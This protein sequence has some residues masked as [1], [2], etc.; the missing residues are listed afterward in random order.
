TPYVT[1]V[2]AVQIDVSE[3]LGQALIPFAIVVVGLSLVLLTIVFRSILVQVKAAFGYL[4]SVLAA[5][6]VV[7]LV[8][9][10]G[11]GASLLGLDQTGPVI[12]FLPIILMGILFGLAMDYEVF[13]VSRIREEHVHG[14]SAREAIRTGFVA[15]SRVVLAAGLI[16][17]AVFAAFVPEG[18]AILKSIALG[19]SVGIFVDAFIVRMTLVPA[20][21]QLLGEKA[22]WLP[23]W[24]DRIL[25]S[26]DVEGEG[27]QHRLALAE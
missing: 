10:H 26:F 9:E 14:R 17:F 27:L 1:G 19:L 21:L 3:Q 20:V 24:L 4:F 11:I 6:G 23:K 12:S 2:T 15:S 16:M 25:P 8:F 7:A 22:W 5:F 13:L 18:D